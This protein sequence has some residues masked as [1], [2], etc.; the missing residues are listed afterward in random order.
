[1]ETVTP[2]QLANVVKRTCA[3]IAKQ[4]STPSG[5]LSAALIELQRRFPDLQR[6]CQA[7]NPDVQRYY[8][9]LSLTDCLQ[10]QAP[11]LHELNRLYGPNAGRVWIVPQLTRIAEFCGQ[12]A[13]WSTTQM[14]EL[15]TIIVQQFGM[16]T[17]CELSWFFQ[18]FKGGRYDRFYGA[19]DPMVLTR[20]LHTYL[21]DRAV[22]CR[23]IE[24]ERAKAERCQ[25]EGLVGIA[26]LKSYLARCR[27]AGK[28]SILEPP[29]PP[30]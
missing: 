24:Q 12:A 18:Q 2:Q 4:P 3:Q 26:A 19:P 30:P 22:A 16:L 10:K 9:Q 14:Q 23:H 5:K 28:V 7:M 6:F 29:P 25:P 15:T 11:T 1:M 8:G 21:S 17:V 13:R 27:Q 20:S